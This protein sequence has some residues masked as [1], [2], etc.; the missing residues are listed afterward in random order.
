MAGAV[1]IKNG[2]KL[3]IAFDADVGTQ[4]EF[5]MICTFAKALDESAF[6]VSIPMKEGKPI[7]LDETQK[8]LFAYG[9]GEDKAIMAG[10][11]DDIVKEGIRNYWKIRRVT[12]QRQFLERVD[13]R[14]QIT[15]RMEYLQET[16]QPNDQGVIQKEE[17]MSVDISAGGMAVFLNR[18]LRV[19]EVCELTLPRLGTAEEG[20]KFE[21][22]VGV[23]CWLRKAPKGSM[24]RNV[25][26]LQFR[27]GNE[28]EKARLNEY[29]GYMKK[30]Y[31][32]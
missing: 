22:L 27:F 1:K 4:P 9:Q 2:T 11:A 12:E 31:K 20:R 7:P 14:Y 18:R 13:E 23:V 29:L 8:I 28:L 5:N 17:A 32:L 24:F 10:Y 21:G 26:G 16:W 3:Q 25:C 30:K 15:L 19:G 6:L